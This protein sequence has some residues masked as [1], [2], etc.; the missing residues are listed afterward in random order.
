MEITVASLVV[1]VVA[2]EED[3][4]QWLAIKAYK[5]LRR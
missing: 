3:K 4:P 1:V 2:E 5:Q